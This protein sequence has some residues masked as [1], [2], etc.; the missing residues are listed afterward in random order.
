MQQNI[1][2]NSKKD[3][4]KTAPYLL[5]KRTKPKDAKFIFKMRTRMYPINC[6]FKNQYG[7]LLSCE[8]CKL[9]E[10]TQEQLLK[11]KVLEH[12]VPRD[13]KNYS[14]LHKSIRRFRRNN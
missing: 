6:N 9:E 11:C 8:L 4:C 1:V 13:E 10:Y 5:D 2:I 7:D 12:F 14:K 3:K